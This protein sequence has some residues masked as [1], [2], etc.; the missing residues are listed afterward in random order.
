MLS[1]YT[2][3]IM[4]STY[5]RSRKLAECGSTSIAG[6]TRGTTLDSASFI[7]ASHH[8]RLRLT[9]AAVFPDEVR[10]LLG[11]HEHR[12]IRIAGGDIGKGRGVDHAQSL[13]AVHAQARIEHGAPGIRTH[14]AR[15]AGVEHRSGARAEVRQNLIVR[16][17][18]WPRLAL[19][20]DGGRECAR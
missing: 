5:Q 3:H 1:V 4:M 16:K 12:G 14:R 8:G 2:R 6:A 10:R 11:E 9:R 18:A 17:H 15:A 20:L 19:G 7:A 13:H